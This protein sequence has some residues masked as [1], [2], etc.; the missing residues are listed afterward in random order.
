MIIR[1]IL[2]FCVLVYLATVITAYYLKIDQLL[3]ILSSPWSSI[4]AIFG[5]L[6]IHIADDG[7]KSM[8][9][10]MILGSIINSVIALTI[11]WKFRKKRLKNDPF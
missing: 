8:K 5:F 7:T 11:I 1:I 10:A 6:I 4:I 3:F 2:T 9:L